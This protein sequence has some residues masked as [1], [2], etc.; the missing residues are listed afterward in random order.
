MNISEA[1]IE[2]KNGCQVARRT[3]SNE[4]LIYHHPI[5][6]NVFERRRFRKY[7]IYLKPC[8]LLENKDGR[9]FMWYP[10]PA[11]LVAEDYIVLNGNPINYL[12]KKI[13]NALN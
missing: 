9:I 10:E 7:V 8:Y 2:I 13:L 12:Q 3:W 11:D 4:W 6:S 5:K 1:L